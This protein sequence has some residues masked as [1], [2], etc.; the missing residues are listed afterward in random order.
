[1]A[2]SSVALS[3]TALYGANLIALIVSS[4]IYGMALA[5]E[6]CGQARR[7][8]LTPSC[9]YMSLNYLRKSYRKDA[10]VLQVMVLTLCLLSSLQV[11]FSSHQVY[12][13]L[14]T[15]HDK[16][17]LSKTMPL[18]VL[19]QYTSV[20]VIKFIGQTFFASRIWSSARAFNTRLAFVAIPVVR[21]PS[22]LIRRLG[23]TTFAGC[24]GP[25]IGNAAR[26]WNIGHRQSFAKMSPASQAILLKATTSIQSGSSA[27]CDIIISVTLCWIFHSH[28]S[29]LKRTNSLISKLIFYAINRAIATSLCALL[30]VFLFRK[31]YGTFYFKIPFLASAQVYVISVVSVLASRKSMRQEHDDTINLSVF[32]R[33]N[34]ASTQKSDTAGPDGSGTITIEAA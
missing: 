7:S 34:L 24:L 10:I 27:L 9:Q 21:I 2:L 19:G 23:P 17:A 29:T 1:M 20:Y 16:P 28:R 18:S 30:T 3:F 12:F 13:I 26:N 33:D 5:S 14:I 25:I 4:W 6:C 22:A 11:A 8:S 31:F 32:M 15:S